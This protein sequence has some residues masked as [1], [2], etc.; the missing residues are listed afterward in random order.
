VAVVGV[1]AGGPGALQF[2]LRH[3]RRTRA[4]LLMAALTQRTPLTDDQL[5]STLGRLVMSPRFQN[6]AYFLI[7]QAMKVMP[8]LALQ[9][10]I[11]TETTYDMD[12]GK[13]VIQQTL[14]DPNQRQQVMA[15]ADAIVPAL[16]RL[17]GVNNDLAVQQHLDDLPFEQIQAPVL[18]VHSRYDGDVP[19]PN[20]TTAHARLPQSDLITVDQFGHFLWWGDPQVTRDFEARITAFLAAHLPA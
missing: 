10:F 3:P 18:I 8:A 20:A 1:S 15:L 19:Y 5:N 17:D 11:R 13:Q 14:A 6:P 7:N 9:D 12:A 4:V 16:P 2:A